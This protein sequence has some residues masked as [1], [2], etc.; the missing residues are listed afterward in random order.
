MLED[1]RRCWICINCL[2]IIFVT[3]LPFSIL[4]G[5]PSFASE[6]PTVITVIMEAG[7][8]K[9]I[10]PPNPSDDF[11]TTEKEIAFAIF[12]DMNP[13]D[14]I[15]ETTRIYREFQTENII[16]ILRYKFPRT[17]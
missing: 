10:L 4:A 13:K 17:K 3:V 5:K 11:E 14:E 12:R 15:L 2:L 6:A 7:V 16:V 9:I 1:T 8:A